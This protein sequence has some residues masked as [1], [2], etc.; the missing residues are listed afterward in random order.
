[1]T[2]D[3]LY[4]ARIAHI[5]RQVFLQFLSRHSDVYPIVTRE[6]SRSFNLGVCRA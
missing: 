3:T 5:S 1:M 4:P 6:I 2:A